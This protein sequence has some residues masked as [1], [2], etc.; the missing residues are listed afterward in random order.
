[1]WSLG[2]EEQFYLVWP[3]VLLAAL[4]VAG[5]RQ[6]APPRTRCRGR[7]QRSRLGRRHGPAYSPGR[8]SR[9][10]RTPTAGRTSS[11][12]GARLALVLTPWSARSA[13]VAR[14]GARTWPVPV[15][16]VADRRRGR[17][18]P[19]T[20]AG[21]LYGGSLLFAL[22]VALVLWPP[23][24][25]ARL[26]AGAGARRRAAAVGRPHLLRLYLWHWP[27]ILWATSFVTLSSPTEVKLLAIALTFLLATASYYL[28]DGRS[29]TARCL[30]RF[31]ESSG[32]RS[33]SPPQSSSSSPGRAT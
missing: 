13:A 25:P 22:V 9:V 23:A 20:A 28:V 29:A 7:R 33:S 16:A 3:L 24:S 2:I 10:L 18:R 21:L 1:M 19:A 17:D 4:R 15:A 12:L 5:R 32:S 27:I 14:P 8:V 6:T 26:G 30:L 11:L 31:P